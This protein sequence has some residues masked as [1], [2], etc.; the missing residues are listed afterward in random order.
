MERRKSPVLSPL[1]FVSLLPPYARPCVHFRLLHPTLH[2]PPLQTPLLCMS[3]SPLLSSPLNPP[4]F[5]PACLADNC[6]KEG[7]IGCLPRRAFL[8]DLQEI[9]FCWSDVL[10]LAGSSSSK[11]PSVCL[12]WSAVALKRV[13]SI[14]DDKQTSIMPFSTWDIKHDDL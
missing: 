1:F 5:I 13:Q 3:Q 7:G 11:T 8:W 10:Q 6:W 2:C 12:R 14:Q 9:L 4:S